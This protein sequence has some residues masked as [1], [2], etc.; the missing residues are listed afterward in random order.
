MAGGDHKQAHAI[1]TMKHEIIHALG[2][3]NT[4]Y[5]FFRDKDGNPMTARE[6]LSGLPPLDNN[7]QYTWSSNITKEFNRPGWKKVNMIVSPAV[8]REARRHFSCDTLE[9]GE[10]EDQGGTGTTGSHWE[11]RIFENEA[12][13]GAL[14]VNPVLSRV[15]LAVLEDT[16]W[17]H[18]NYKM[19][20]PLRYGF[21]EGCDFVKKSCKE[22]MQMKKAVGQS[23]LPYCDILGRENLDKQSCSADWTTVNYC[24][25][26]KGPKLLD[27]KY[28]PFT[29]IAGVNATDVPYYGG[30]SE[31]ADYCPFWTKLGS[32]TATGATGDSQCKIASNQLADKRNF[33][34]ELFCTECLCFKL[35]GQFGLKRTV[36]S[37]L[38]SPKGGGGC[39]KIKCAATEAAGLKVYVDDTPYH[40]TSTGQE[41]SVSSQRNAYL[42]TGVIICPPYNEVCKNMTAPQ[43]PGD[44]VL[45]G[46]TTGPGGGSGGGAGGESGGGSGNVT[47]ATTLETS[48]A[49]SVLSVNWIVA[50]YSVMV[51]MVLFSHITSSISHLLC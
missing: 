36:G 3:S 9:G 32:T 44:D 23:L 4:L 10:L 21:K 39:Y 6:D 11:K 51:Q 25:L 50:I 8:V 47:P 26:W 20:E 49:V 1:A 35:K 15:T 24:N 5:G 28:Q 17:Y 18:V 13:T 41:V 27:A 12:M 16:G 30:Y 29:S 40:C 38:R 45:W 42:H 43:Y 19:A 2:F 33:L 37:L 48:S 34:R 7:F 22:Y 46:V 31:M 14:T